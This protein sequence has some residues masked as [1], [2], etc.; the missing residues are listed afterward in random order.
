MMELQANIHSSIYAALLQVVC[1]LQTERP[2][3]RDRTT[4]WEPGIFTIPPPTFL[5]AIHVLVS[6]ILC[7]PTSL[8][9]F[10]SK[11]QLQTVVQ[12]IC[13]PLLTILLDQSQMK[14]DCS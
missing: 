3:E 2:N 13:P 5:H 12:K 7:F 1:T 9:V 14:Q 11:I 4:P 10:S 6:V 8:S